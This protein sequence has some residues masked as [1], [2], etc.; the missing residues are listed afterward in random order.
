MKSIYWREQKHICGRDYDTAPYMEVDLYPVTPAKHK[1]SARAKKK[2]ASSLAQQRYTENRAKRYHVQLA[3]TNFRR[4]D[5]SWTGTYDDDH[6]P[7][8]GDKE[9]AD[10]DA[11]NFIKRVYRWCDK[12]GVKHPKWMLATE[13]TTVEPDG[14]IVGRHH[15]HAIIEHT[16]G[17]TRDVLEEL[18]IDQTKKRIG[19]TRC[20]YLDIDHGSVES[21]V[22]Y[23]SKNKRCA[24]SWRQSRGLEKPK[25]PPPNDSKWSRKKL[26]DASTLYIDDAAFWEKQYPGYT[27]NR[28]E[29]SV[30]DAGMRHTVVI[31]R[32][33]ECWH[34]GG[35]KKKRGAV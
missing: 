20:E 15:H 35:G 10:K 1:A 27:L 13:Y 9:R 30:T 14:S 25:T 12:H 16:E 6:L 8:P 32:R 2:E 21:L 7:A 18:W 19:L 29:T 23:I 28:V 4:G 22:K 33:A 3:N 5:F 26:E 24:R 11:T 17:L 31:L 34:G